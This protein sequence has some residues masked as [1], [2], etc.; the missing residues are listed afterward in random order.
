MLVIGLTGA[1]A[2]G[3]S[4]VAQCFAEL[5]CEI[6]DADV[7]GHQ[8]LRLPQTI[9]KI[10]NAFGDDVILDG[11]VDRRRLAALV[12]SN[13]SDAPSDELKMLESITHPVI[14]EWMNLRLQ[15]IERANLAP[16]AVLDA[17][18]MFKAQWDRFCDRI[19]FVHAD[20][21]IRHQRSMQR[22][23]P[24]GELQRRERQQLPVDQKRQRASD[25]IDNSESAANTRK[26]VQSLWHQW[27]PRR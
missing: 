12:F 10:Q 5:G 22:G 15:E 20:P 11:Q 13:D 9:K 1:I 14:G 7:I 25:V 17:P 24:E 18:V 4:F 16:A 21:E 23:W 26:Q 19:V 2:S 8:V 27:L 6:V 3:K